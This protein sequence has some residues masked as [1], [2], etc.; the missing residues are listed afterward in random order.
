M[1]RV[2]SVRRETE[3]EAT[4]EE[5]GE[6]KRGSEGGIG[7]RI[8]RGERKTYDFDL[9]VLGVVDYEGYESIRA[10]E[11][12]QWSLATSLWGATEGVIMRVTDGVDFYN[13]LY[14]VPASNTRTQRS[15][16]LGRKR[17]T[18]AKFAKPSEPRPILYAQ[19]CEGVRR[20]RPPAEA[21]EQR[22]RERERSTSGDAK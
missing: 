16:N 12:G 7:E 10:V 1:G 6:K 19:F 2:N 21:T 18:E 3:V 17:P 9:K 14:R 13:I 20:D 11:L 4:G 8:R 22:E 5:G 15:S